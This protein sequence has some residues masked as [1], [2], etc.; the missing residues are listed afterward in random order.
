MSR[1]GVCGCADYKWLNVPYD[2]AVQFTRRPDLQVA[3][4]RNAAAYLGLPTE[5]PDFVHLT[6]ESS[7]RLRALPAWFA[8][9]AYGR[10]GHRDI[11]ERNV[12]AAHR[13]GELLA[14][15]PKIRL[16][17]PVRLNAVC[18]TVPD[19]QHVCDAVAASGEMA[20]AAALTNGSERLPLAELTPYLSVIVLR[21]VG[22][23]PV[24]DF[25]ALIRFLRR[26][27]IESG[28]ALGAPNPI[29][30]DTDRPGLH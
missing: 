9:T 8:L 29:R 4:F 5:D 11:V 21:C 27:A 28:R 13:L 26:S 3:V 24:H 6:P 20:R 17:A 10:A 16:L 14:A 15:H 12:D 19:P 7:R 18:F 25:E 30:D 23:D 2:A 22:G 1:T